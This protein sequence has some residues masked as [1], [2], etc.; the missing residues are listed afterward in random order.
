MPR[1]LI[2]DTHEWMNN[3]PTVPVFTIY[4]LGLPCKEV[5]PPL[6]NC[7]CS[8]MGLTVRGYRPANPWS[9]IKKI[10]CLESPQ[11]FLKSFLHEC[12]TVLGK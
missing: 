9:P 8:K 11:K 4:F 6:S 3:I 2:S 10:Y 1:H 7:H 5:L 12:A